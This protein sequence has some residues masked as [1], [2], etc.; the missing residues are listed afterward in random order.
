M[1]DGSVRSLKTTI[2]RATYL[3]LSTVGGGE[4]ISSDQY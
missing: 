3:A 1:G 2:N 4:V